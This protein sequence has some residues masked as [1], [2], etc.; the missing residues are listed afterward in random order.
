MRTKKLLHNLFMMLAVAFFVGCD[1]EPVTEPKPEPKPESTVDVEVGAITD[2]TIE[3]VIT[4]TNVDKVQYIA[5]ESVDK[6][7]GRDVILNIGT[8]VEANTSA[9]VLVEDLNA[10]V[11]HTIYVVATCGESYLETRASAKTEE[12]VEYPATELTIYE[13]D[14]TDTTATFII[15]TANAE[16]VKYMVKLADADY[17]TAEE[18]ET[19]GIAV[20][21]N[22]EEAV[23]VTGL[24]AE[25]EYFFAVM[26]AGKGLGSETVYPF[27]TCSAPQ[28]TASLGDF[29]QDYVE[30]TVDFKNVSEIKYV[31]IEA[32]TRE[33]TAEQVLKNGVAISD[34][35]VRVEGLK[36]GTSYEIYVAV[37]NASGSMAMADVLTFTTAKNIIE[38]AMS[39]STTASAN[40]YTETNY[41][42]TFTDAVNGYKLNVDFYIAEGNEYLTSGEYPLAG[43]NAGEISAPYT[44]F[45]F[46]PADTVVTTFSSGSVTVVATP[47]EDT[48]EVYYEVSGVFYF[49]DENYVTL[50]YSGLIEGIALP[51]VV[52]GAPEGAY[53]F[54]VS[55]S[56]SMPKR[57]HGSNLAVGEYYIKF[58]DSNWNELT[59]D[60][61]VDP[62]LCDNG[63]DG[64]PAGTYTMADGSF[65]AYSNISLYNPYF[66]GNFTEAELKVSVEGDN[67]TFV[68]L[69]TVVSGATEKV[70]YMSYTGEIKDM[71]PQQ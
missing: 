4:S 35:T 12:A 47:N 33:V 51:E 69:G 31:C 9:T 10:D 42:V 15:A 40:K 56:T 60:L 24:E 49:A 29:G 39:A 63:N 6:A 11:D 5:L 46:T 64:L 2:T 65:N 66:A 50:N 26:A 38:Y 52:E 58:Y 13:G 1:K 23:T 71:V 41:Y 36:E 22:V 3:F 18:W 20:E 28:V 67:Y 25:T 59:I 16:V 62:E 70:I 8:E 45:M 7:P 44:S 14:I 37:K 21:P 27:T 57:V 55:P 61:F 54:E 17:P 34:T 30:F 43:F 48:R 19:D 68:L 32:G 53:V